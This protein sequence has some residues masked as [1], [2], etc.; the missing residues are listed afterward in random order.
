V[1]SRLK[2]SLR[3]QLELEPRRLAR[4]ASPRW[5]RQV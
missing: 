3:L 2:P 5:P 1:N 4:C